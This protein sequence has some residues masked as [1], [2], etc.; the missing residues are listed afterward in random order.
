MNE[1]EEN[2]QRK[3]Y[4]DMAQAKLNFVDNI[5]IVPDIFIKGKFGIRSSIVGDASINKPDFHIYNPETGEYMKKKYIDMVLDK[6]VMPTARF[7]HQ[8]GMYNIFEYDFKPNAKNLLN[9]WESKII[10]RFHWTWFNAIRDILN[11]EWFKELNKFTNNMQRESFNVFPA[12]ENVYRVFKQD[13]STIKCVLLAQDP[14]PNNHANGIAFATDKSNKPKS[15]QL[16]E[17]AIKEDMNYPDDW[18][19]PNN[20]N[21]LTQQGIMLLNSALTVREKE[22]NSHSE[23]WKPFIQAVLETLSNQNK[24][25]VFIL[26]GAKAQSFKKYIDGITHTVLE[27]E[28]PARAAYEER[29]WEYNNIFSKTSDIINITTNQEIKW[30][31]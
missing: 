17:K 20:L 22:P 8:E 31:P 16:L 14:Y 11:S 13:L 29:E 3:E 15:L 12:R 5:V 2:K 23:R 7:N 19:L 4:W 26:L 25:I 24:Q 10:T 21:H 18:E 28:H 27:A 1:Y 6:Y 30:I 9:E